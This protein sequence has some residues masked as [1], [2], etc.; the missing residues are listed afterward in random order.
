MGAVADDR[1]GFLGQGSEHE[2]PGLAVVEHWPEP[3]IQAVIGNVR[4]VEG[5]NPVCEPQSVAE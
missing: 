4:V 3:V 5:D 1:Q 2:L